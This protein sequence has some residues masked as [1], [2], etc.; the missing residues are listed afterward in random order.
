MVLIRNIKKKNLLLSI[1][2]DSVIILDGTVTDQHIFWCLGHNSAEQ[3]GETAARLHFL[4]VFAHCAKKICDGALDCM[5]KERFERGWDN[6]KYIAQYSK[7]EFSRLKS[8]IC[9]K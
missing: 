6:I 4:Q 5:S 7:R 3:K 8:D 1:F 9:K 2:V